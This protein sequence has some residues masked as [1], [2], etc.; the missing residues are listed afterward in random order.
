MEVG[1][2]GAGNATRTIGRHLINVGHT[3]VASNSRGPE[4]FSEFVVPEALKGVDWHGRIL[5]DATNARVDSEP[6]LSLAGVARLRTALKGPHLQRDGRRDGRWRADCEIN[7]QH[8]DGMDTGLLAGQTP[9]RRLYV[10]RR[11]RSQTECNRVNQQHW[12]SRH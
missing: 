5:V 7:Q 6:D 12:T 2:I 1:F 11:R 3:V 8:A 4:T 9:N 10:R